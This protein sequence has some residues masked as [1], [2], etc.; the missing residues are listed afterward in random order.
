MIEK[1]V[2]KNN[3]AIERGGAIYASSYEKILMKNITF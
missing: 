1:T 3:V 2:F